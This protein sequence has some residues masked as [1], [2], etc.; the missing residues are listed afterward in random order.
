MKTAV[1][2]TAVAGLIAATAGAANI[3][4]QT[5]LTISGTADVSITGSLFGTWAPGDDYY[6]SGIYTVNGVEFLTYGTPGVN[7]GVSS[8]DSGN[9]INMDRYNG[10]GNPNTADSNYNS[11]LQV[12]MFNW[13]SPNPINLSWDSMTVGHTYLFEAWLNDGRSG[14]SG[15]SVFT[16]GTS[17]SNPVLIGDGAPGQ[18]ITGTFVADNSSQSVV[19]SAGIMLN[20]VQVRDITPTPEPSTLAFLAIGTGALVIGYRRKKRTT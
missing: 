16:G 11:L 8:A 19:M 13:S 7:F 6:A 20:L 12:A 5:P 10:F 4:W 9:P 18:Y 17:A 2:C 15:S 3:T 1:L 14:H